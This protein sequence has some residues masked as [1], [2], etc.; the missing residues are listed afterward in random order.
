M[1]TDFRRNADIWIRIA[2]TT[3]THP[4]NSSS[5]VV[6]KEGGMEGQSALKF[7][8]RLIT[9]YFSQVFFSELC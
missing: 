5:K 7:K 9:D 2:R 4:Y 3:E 1:I 8:I 6:A